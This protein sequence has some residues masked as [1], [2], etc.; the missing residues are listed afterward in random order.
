M[1]IDYLSSR[2]SEERDR[3]AEAETPQARAAH[4]ALAEQYQAEIDRLQSNHNSGNG[5]FATA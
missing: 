3:A 2:M 1:D 4:I 5:T